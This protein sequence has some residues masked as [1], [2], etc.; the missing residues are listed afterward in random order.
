MS[1]SHGAAYNYPKGRFSPLEF[2]A[3]RL[4]RMEGRFGFNYT[5]RPNGD[6]TFNVP[7]GQERKFINEISKVVDFGCTTAC[8]VFGFPAVFGMAA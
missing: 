6:V 4:A 8:E 3:I 7:L 2:Q 1:F 5:R